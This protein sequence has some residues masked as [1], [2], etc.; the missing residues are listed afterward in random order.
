MCGLAVWASGPCTSSAEDKLASRTAACTKQSL[1]QRRFCSEASG[2]LARLDSC[3]LS[4]KSSVS[5]APSTVLARFGMNGGCLSGNGFRMPR[6]S[7]LWNRVREGGVP[8]LV[9]SVAELNAFARESPAM[10]SNFLSATDC[11]SLKCQVCDWESFPWHGPGR[12]ETW[13][14]TRS[15]GGLRT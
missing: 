8:L 7:Q 4:F 1:S 14:Y 10:P 6:C 11:S 12:L 13:R 9:A 2:L 3:L 15:A 5:S